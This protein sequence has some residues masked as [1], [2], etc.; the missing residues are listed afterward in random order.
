MKSIYTVY[1]FDGND[2]FVLGEFN[3]VQDAI[4]YHKL[5]ANVYQTVF[6]Q[7]FVK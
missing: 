2:T 6:I 7:E 1:G 3:K 4:K 5:M